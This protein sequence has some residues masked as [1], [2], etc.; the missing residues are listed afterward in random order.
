MPDFWRIA[1]VLK[2]LREKNN[3]V[4]QIFGWLREVLYVQNPVGGKC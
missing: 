3:S 1:A 2:N 4:L